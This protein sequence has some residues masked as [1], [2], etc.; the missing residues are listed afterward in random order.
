M[1]APTGWKDVLLI[2]VLTAG[3]LAGCSSRPVPAPVVEVFQGTSATQRQ[4]N[5]YHGKTYTVKKGDTL[6]SIAWI[7]GNDYR[8][9]A[10]INNIAPP[11][12]IY[13]GQQLNLAAGVKKA[14]NLSP[15][16][17]GQTSTK[18][19]TDPVDPPNKQAYGES[20]KIVNK[21]A[22]KALERTFPSRVKAWRWPASGKVINKFSAREHGNKG[23]DIAGNR[24]DKILAAA[25]GKVVYTGSALRGFGKLVIIKHSESFLSAYAHNDEIFVKEQQ[26]VSAGQRIAS[27]GSSDADRVM[28]HFEVRYK[29]KSVDPLRYLPK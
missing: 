7:S 29:G 3:I 14:V 13:P 10:A 4:A 6:F 21:T 27:M 24:G 17:T 9:I 15:A 12:N 2:V 16:K 23:I 20:K 18:K 25:D 1:M 8:D 11:Y 22:D 26:W 5:H 19:R 28:L